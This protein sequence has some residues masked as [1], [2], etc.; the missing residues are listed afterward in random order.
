MR[1][2]P[3]PPCPQDWELWTEVSTEPGSHTLRVDDVLVNRSSYEREYQ[4]IYHTN[5]G[6]PILGEGATFE[7]PVASVSPFNAQAAAEVGSWQTYQGP[8]AH[9][10]ETVFCVTPHS[11]ASGRTLVAL[12]DAA[13]D[14]GIS[15]RY[16]T[17]SLP[18]LS[19]WK[20]TDTL[21]EGYVTG[22][23]PG[24]GFPYRRELERKAGRVPTLPPGGST[25]FSLEWQL[26]ADAAAVSATKAEIR[27][28][29]RGRATTVAHCARGAKYE[30]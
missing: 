2:L 12:V 14:R 10:G 15:C 19:L 29:E 11:D 6:P 20:N 8:T 30:P 1:R 21:E 3:V 17:G 28:I 25:R 16:T 23:E 26:L 4:I 27:A 5:F 9:Y 24:S 7:A 18:S 13:G 22:I